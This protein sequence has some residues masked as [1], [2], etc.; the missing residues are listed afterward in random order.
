MILPL[1]SWGKKKERKV[2][3]IEIINKILNLRHGIMAVLV[4]LYM[5]VTLSD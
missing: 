4:S 1:V 5:D 3:K 2:V